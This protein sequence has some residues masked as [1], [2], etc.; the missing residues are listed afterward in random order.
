MATFGCISL[1]KFQ[2]VLRIV[3][4][5]FVPHRTAEHRPAGLHPARRA[6]RRG[7]EKKIGIGAARLAQDGQD[8]FAVV[9]NREAHQFGVG[10]TL[11]IAVD[12]GRIVACAHAGA[13]YVE[14]HFRRMK[15]LMEQRFA[16]RGRKLVEGEA[17][18]VGD[19]GT[20]AQNILEFLVWIEN[21]RGRR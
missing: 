1:K 21:D 2:K 10:V 17:G 11:I 13:A 19:G 4:K 14:P 16:R 20:K 6:P 3:S 8:V 5:I 15:Q 18:R 9:I 7:E 12:P